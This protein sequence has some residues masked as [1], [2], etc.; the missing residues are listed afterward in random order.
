MKGLKMRI[1]K[2]EYL[3][4]GKITDGVK[5][6]FV[7]RPTEPGFY[8]KFNSFLWGQSTTI[9]EIGEGM[10]SINFLGSSTFALLDEYG[11]N[12]LFDNY[13]WVQITF[14][15]PQ[16]NVPKKSGIYWVWRDDCLADKMIVNYNAEGG[17]Y[18][19]IGESHSTSVVNIRDYNWQ[20]VDG[21]K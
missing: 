10:N 7:E 2:I 9:V 11:R 13:N 14:E 4:S 6:K 21:P 15:K 20:L 19:V 3:K 1:S 5:L 8:I 17:Y 16:D 12:K 18:Q